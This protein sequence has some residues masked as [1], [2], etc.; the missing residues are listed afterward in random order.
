MYTYVYIYIYIRYNISLYMYKIL[1]TKSSLKIIKNISERRAVCE[2]KRFVSG[3]R[4]LFVHV[5]ITLSRILYHP[6]LFSPVSFLYIYRVSGHNYR[7]KWIL[8]SRRRYL[9]LGTIIL[10]GTQFHSVP[11]HCICLPFVLS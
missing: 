7:T 8:N 2:D 11:V 9:C 3:K 10:K 4:Y 1:Y 6:S 5:T